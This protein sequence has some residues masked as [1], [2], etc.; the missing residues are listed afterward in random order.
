MT[1]SS[2]PV[3]FC[4]VLIA[5]MALFFMVGC[6]SPGGTI[7]DIRK[8]LDAFKAK[9]SEA[10]LERMEKSFV[11]IDADIKDFEDR[12]DL[13]QADLYRRQAMMLRQEYRAL[14]GAYNAWKAGQVV[15][16]GSGK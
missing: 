1:T 7:H 11:N 15:P 4:A 5:G 6:D 16:A 9:P 8:N 3:R 12:G 10:L 13:A 14:R 2:L